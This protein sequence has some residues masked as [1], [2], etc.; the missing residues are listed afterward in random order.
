MPQIQSSS[1]SDRPAIPVGDHVLVLVEVKPYESDN[2]Y[3]KDDEPESAA[4][5]RRKS[6]LIWQFVTG[7]TDGD[8][9]QYEHAIWTGKFYGDPRANLTKLLDQILPGQSE[10]TKAA[11]NTDILLGSS[12]KAMVRTV[13]NKKGDLVPKVVVIEPAKATQTDA[14]R[15]TDDELLDFVSPVRDRLPA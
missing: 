14:P 2:I 10:E 1:A 9:T 15:P 3:F 4:N 5:P 6:Q 12:Y 11:L 7:V 8:G 13:K